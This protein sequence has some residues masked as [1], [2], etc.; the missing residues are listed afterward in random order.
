MI[1]QFVVK[2]NFCFLCTFYSEK[3]CLMVLPKTIRLNHTKRLPLI[4][5]P[6]LTQGFPDSFSELSGEGYNG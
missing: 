1:L 6:D 5:P 2:L 3:P 4:L